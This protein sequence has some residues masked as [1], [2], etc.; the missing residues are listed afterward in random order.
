[1]VCQGES[2]WRLHMDLTSIG[3]RIKYARELKGITQEEM[4]AQLG[5]DRSHVSKWETLGVIPR[6]QTR[7]KIAECLNVSNEWLR[8]GEGTPE[9]P[10]PLDEKSNPG[11]LEK[12][13]DLIRWAIA[14]PDYFDIGN[15]IPEMKRLRKLRGDS[16]VD[17]IHMKMLSNRIAGLCLERNVHLEP[18]KFQA[19]LDASWQ[20]GGGFYSGPD[21]KILNYMIS[22]AIA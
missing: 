10:E 7:L 20:M 12:L 5:V 13:S 2:E 19:I 8:T 16:G 15:D 3:S 4:G 14:Q 21:D 17:D 9:P 1:M 22:I 6:G 18:N 11:N